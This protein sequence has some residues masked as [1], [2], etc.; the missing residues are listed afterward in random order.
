MD[1]LTVPL[2]ECV[3]VT[4]GVH[5]TA[6][7]P[8]VVKWNQKIWCFPTKWKINWKFDG[9]LTSQPSTQN[10]QGY[11]LNYVRNQSGEAIFLRSAPLLLV[12]KICKSTHSCLC[13]F[14]FFDVLVCIVQTQLCLPSSLHR[15]QGTPT[16]VPARHTFPC[17]FKPL[18]LNFLCLHVNHPRLAVQ[19]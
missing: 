2:W 14:R 13:I 16:I 9:R 6:C 17:Y 5:L 4:I 1:K 18:G 8:R 19:L 10:F 11:L 15:N 7:W 3:L 12:G